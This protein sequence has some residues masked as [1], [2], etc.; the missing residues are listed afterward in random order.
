MRIEMKETIMPKGCLINERRRNLI[1]FIA[2]GICASAVSLVGSA[3]AETESIAGGRGTIE[4]QDFGAIKIHSFL[5]GPDG[6]CVN[7]HIVESVNTLV[8]FDSQ[9]LDKYAILFADYIDGLVKPVD[10]IVLSHG[11][12]DHWSGMQVL[13]MRF[14]NAPIYALDGVGEGIYI[15]DE[16]MLA[17]MRERFGSRVAQRPSFPIHVLHEGTMTVDGIDY[18]LQCIVDAECELQLVAL[19][20]E[21]KVLFAFDLV[22][23]KRDHVFVASNNFDHWLRVL[24]TLEQME[25]YETII[26][27]HGKS[28]DRT[29]I[30][31][32]MSY[33]R[34]AKIS[35]EKN[36]TSGGYAEHLKTYFRQHRHSNWVDL[37]ANLLYLERKPD[38]L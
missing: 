30:G 3:Y 22:F 13:A 23:G 19:L 20:P 12:A 7:S 18:A 14:P 17:L 15:R 38:W 37:S 10:R 31:A 28:T 34:E 35:Y 33:L 9:L 5:S 4:V 1:T 36:E 32:T 21:H 25:G 27:G 26:L 11:H 6:F 16:H 24:D 8:V 29:A 2:G